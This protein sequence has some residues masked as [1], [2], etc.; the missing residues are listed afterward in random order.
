MQFCKQ[1]SEALLSP[2]DGGDSE[3][4]TSVKGNTFMKVKILNA[5][6]AIKETIV[7]AGILLSQRDIACLS[8]SFLLLRNI[9]TITITKSQVLRGRT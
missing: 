9:H 6:C 7:R 8:L 4:I 2:G 3:K 5:C 1:F